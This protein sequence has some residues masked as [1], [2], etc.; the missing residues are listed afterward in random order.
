MT[1]LNVLTAEMLKLRRTIAVPMVIL[2]PLLIAVFI[3]VMGV[4][5]PFSTLNRNGVSGEWAALTRASLRFWASLMLPLLITLE[6][7]LL[8]G[9][10][11]SE[12]QWKSLLT[13]PL[14]RWNFYAV[15][16]LV[17]LALIVISSAILVLGILLNGAILPRVQPELVFA[18]P[19]PWFDIARQGAEVFCL[20]FLLL[21][22]QNWVAL[23]WKSFSVAVGVGIVGL[24]M[25]FFMFV[26]GQQSLKELQLFPWSLPILVLGGRTSLDV[27]SGLIF[28]VSAGVFVAAVGC[29]DFCHREVQ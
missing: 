24:V 28:S 2:A 14:P 12:C 8:A 5:A 23:R 3:F 1:A 7:A 9:L 21:V 18:L 6:T 26:A 27:A 25:G 10:E 11:H 4:N 15:K 17:E 13:R 22:I 20:A 29:W 19:I 16:L